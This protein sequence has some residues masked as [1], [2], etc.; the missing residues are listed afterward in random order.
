MSVAQPKRASVQHQCASDLVV[1]Q[2]DEDVGRDLRGSG[3]VSS[4]REHRHGEDV[5]SGAHRG[6]VATSRNDF[7]RAYLEL[8]VRF[9]PRRTYGECLL[10]AQL[11]LVIKKKSAHVRR[12]GVDGWRPV[13]GN[14][15][16]ETKRSSIAELR[17]A[18]LDTAGN[19]HRSW[20]SER[21]CSV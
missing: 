15:T 4:E 2:H 8:D 18:R 3:G 19:W 13:Q 17:P 12:D 5:S 10:S 11:V 9:S 7:A 20:F 14:M 1:R 16:G 6:D 21:H